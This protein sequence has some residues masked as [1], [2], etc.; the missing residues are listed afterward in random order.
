MN[1]DLLKFFTFLFKIT[2]DGSDPFFPNRETPSLCS[3]GRWNLAQ[4][5]H[6]SQLLTITFILLLDLPKNCASSSFVL[7]YLNPISWISWICWFVEH[8][9]QFCNEAIY[10][11]LNFNIYMR[12]VAK[13]VRN[14]CD[15]ISI[16]FL[17]ICFWLVTFTLLAIF[18]N[19]MTSLRFQISRIVKIFWNLSH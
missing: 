15:L 16:V 8:Q 17:E 5:I 9:G 1:A 7:V 3:S 14:G 11:S 10:V 2:E 4:T 18:I 12:T 6:Y 19:N 13:F